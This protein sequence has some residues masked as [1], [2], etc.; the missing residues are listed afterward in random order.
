[1]NNLPYPSKKFKG[2]VRRLVTDSKPSPLKKSLSLGGARNVLLN[3]L[4]DVGFGSP[5]TFGGPI[6]MPAV[7]RISQ[8]GLRFNQFHTTALCS[9]TRA[10][11]LTGRN[12]HSVHM[13]GITEVANSFPGYD[14]V[15]PKESATVAKILKENDYSTGCFGK[16]HITP[17][18]EQGPAGPFDRWPTGMGFDAASEDYQP[19]GGTGP[20]KPPLKKPRGE[21]SETDFSRPE[22]A[23]S[24]W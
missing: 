4:D 1:M 16:W 24:A 3:M 9:P 20:K 8:G 13:G 14:S 5:A 21:I 10:S 12:H 17:S 11:L 6:A 7:E 23:R 15:I 19:P 22:E 2:K 18:W